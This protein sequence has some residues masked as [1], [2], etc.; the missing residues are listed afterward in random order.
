MKRLVPCAALALSVGLVGCS[1]TGSVQRSVA[2]VVLPVSEE[3][4]LGEQMEA[5][6]AQELTLLDDPE[7][8]GYVRQLG[9]RIVAAAGDEVPEGIEFEFDVV[10]DDQTVNAFAIPGGHIYVYTGLLRAARDEAELMGVLG[11]EVAHVTRRHI[12]QQL[13][14]QF[15]AETL[16]SLIGSSGGL[17]GLV[18]QLAGSV[19][20]QGFLLKY[21]R[22]AERDADH[23]GLA[24]EARAGWDPHGMIDFFSMLERQGDRGGAPSF[25]LTHPEPGERVENARERIEELQP[26][27]DNRGRERYQRM[28]ARLGGPSSASPAK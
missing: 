13:T 22:D 2:A 25:L 3:N 18:G 7:V 10:D 16:L 6:L 27:P 17:T 8:V 4:K 20:A 11:H 15:G 9:Q 5:Q 26:V 19:G 1:T 21:S 28:V 14:A 12:A 24:Y 23:V